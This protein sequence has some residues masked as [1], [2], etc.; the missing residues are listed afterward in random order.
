MCA[1]G[2]EYKAGGASTGVSRGGKAEQIHWWRQQDRE[3]GNCHGAENAP[4]QLPATSV[5]LNLGITDSVDW[6]IL[7]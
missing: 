5:F 4:C 3:V 6:I 7:C 2:Q 1:E